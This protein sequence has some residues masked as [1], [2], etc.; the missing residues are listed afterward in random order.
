[1]AFENVFGNIDF[2]APNRTA[3]AEQQAFAGMIGDAINTRQR[4]EAMELERRKVEVQAK[5][6]NLDKMAQGE[7]LKMQKGLPYDESVIRAASVFKG[8]QTYIDPYTQQM[9]TKPTLAQRAGIG[10]GGR[11]NLETG[12]G[13][14][15]GQ[16]VA[17]VQRT[18]VTDFFEQQLAP[19]PDM[20]MQRPLSVNDLPI[21]PVYIDDG[22]GAVQ[23]PDYQPPRNVVSDEPEGF[24]ALPKPTKPELPAGLKGTPRGDLMEYE[25]LSKMGEAEYEA[26]I[27]FAKQQL[28]NEK[29]KKQVGDILDRM[30]QINQLLKNED[31][32]IHGDMSGRQKLEAYA[33]TSNIGMEARKVNN[34]QVQSLAEEYRNLQATL[35]PFYASAAG[36]G[37]KS[38]DSEGERK[39]I[40]DSFGSPQGIFEANDR[41]LNNLRKTFGVDGGV[42]ETPEGA[43]SW[44]EYFK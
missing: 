22:F 39:S 6:L 40:L 16:P 9:V 3:F 19:A 35:L 43:V 24:D 15:T 42:S 17:P 44:E 8:S 12:A 1:M 25:A 30:A 26:R 21:D 36:L 2:Q 41:Q 28:K 18:Q 4:K 33:A 29:G 37:A 31:A 10:A 11:V 27:D 13:T 38:L 34:P 7:I 32:I 23:T 5:E 14:F 20:S